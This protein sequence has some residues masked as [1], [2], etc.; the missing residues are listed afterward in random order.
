MAHLKKIIVEKGI[1]QSKVARQADIPQ[2]NFNLICNDKLSPC[3][4]WRNRI[5]IVLGIPEE[6]LFP[7]FN[8]KEGN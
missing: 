5:S 7:E 8:E 6:D 4:A 3:P 2:S 1:S